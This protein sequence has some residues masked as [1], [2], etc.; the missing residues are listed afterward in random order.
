MQILPYAN[1]STLETLERNIAACPSVTDLLHEGLSAKDITEK[2][3]HGLGVS[4]NSFSMEPSY[5]PCEAVALQQ[6]MK[7]AVALLGPEEI[8]KLLEEE[9]KIE[10]RDL[11]ISLGSESCNHRS[12]YLLALLYKTFAS[13]KWYYDT[14]IKQV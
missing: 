3:L 11:G 2:L 7:R 6:R 13:A 14:E 9:G 12:T 4:E 8:D 5:G 1:E 10:V